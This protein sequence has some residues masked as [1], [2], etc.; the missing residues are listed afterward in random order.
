[1][2]GVAILAAAVIVLVAADV[3][4]AGGGS[5]NSRAG[6]SPVPATQG[7]FPGSPALPILSVSALLFV[8]ERE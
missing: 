3:D 7:S 8:C 2:K 6:S 1:M 5:G 4:A